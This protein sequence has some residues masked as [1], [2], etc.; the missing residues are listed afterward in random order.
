MKKLF[1]SIMGIAVS[2][3][4]MAAMP[5][6][7]S[8]AVTP[9]AAQDSV[10][11]T[12]YLQGGPGIAI[13]GSQAPENMPDSAKTFLNKF[14][15]DDPVAQCHEDFIKQTYHVILEDGTDITFNKQGKVRD[16]KNGGNIALSPD[17]LK[18]ILPAKT[19]KHL[20]Q[21]GA[22]NDVSAVKDAGEKGFGVALLNN[23]PP[24]MIFDV[25]GTFIIVAG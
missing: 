2:V 17:L 8:E 21:A 22:L 12:F 16:I 19:V 11:L 14:Y 9:T 4:S 24:Q 5:P 25:D 18:A 13:S 15:A 7:A 6:V 23:V 10:P 20:G 3:M 1:L